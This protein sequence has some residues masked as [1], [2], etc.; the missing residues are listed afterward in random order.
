M[1]SKPKEKDSQSDASDIVHVQRPRPNPDCDLNFAVDITIVDNYYCYCWVPGGNV[2]VSSMSPI[3][4]QPGTPLELAVGPAHWAISFP[5]A[6]I[7]V[8]KWG[9]PGLAAGA[10]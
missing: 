10:P 4:S 1:N 6:D 3:R 8:S 2:L 9:R 5:K 7:M